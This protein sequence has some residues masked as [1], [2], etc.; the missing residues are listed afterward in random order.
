MVFRTLKIRSA[1]FYSP[2]GVHVGYKVSIK[3]FWL[4]KS[5]ELSYRAKSL[6]I[7]VKSTSVH[8]QGARDHTY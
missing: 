5:S 2:T 3:S 8:F 6:G 1:F 4:D 7:E